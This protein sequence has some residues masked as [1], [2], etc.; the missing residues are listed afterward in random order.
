MPFVVNIRSDRICLTSSAGIDEID[1]H[2]VGIWNTV[3]VRD[4]QR[5]FENL[6]DGTPHIDD[7]I[8]CGEELVSFL[9]Q[10][11]WNT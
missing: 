5:I 9:G 2:K 3:G 4:S 10:M 8:A 11:M 1:D 7:L 6:L